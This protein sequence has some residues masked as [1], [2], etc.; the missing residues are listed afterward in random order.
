MP[1]FTDLTTHADLNPGGLQLADQCD[2]LSGTDGI[3][4]LLLWHRWEREIDECRGIDI[5]VPIARID[6]QSA[7]AGNLGGDSFGIGGVLLGNELVVVTLNEDRA[8]PA[9]GNCATQDA[10]GVIGG[11][12]EGV[13]LLRTRQL[14]DERRAVHRGGSFECRTSHGEDLAAK[15]ERRHGEALVGVLCARSVERRNA[16]AVDSRSSGGSA[17]QPLGRSNGRLVG[18]EGGRPGNGCSTA[19]A[20]LCRIEDLNGSRGRNAQRSA[21]N[22]PKICG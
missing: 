4:A 6:R 17:C 19:L 1:H 7:G 8:A 11:A 12:L 14:E 18:G 20:Q 16:C 10:R 9:G 5:D 3:H 15:V 2:R 22:L 21:Q 13:G